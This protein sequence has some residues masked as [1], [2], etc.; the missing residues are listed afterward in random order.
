MVRGRTR[1]AVQPGA[2]G[3]SRDAL[4]AALPAPLQG[5]FRTGDGR[6]RTDGHWW[7]VWPLDRLV[8]DNLDARRQ[9]TLATGFL[10]FGDDGTGDGFCLPADGADEVVRWSWIDQEVVETIGNV[11]HF[12]AEWV[13]DQ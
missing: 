5:V 13:P 2:T 6:F 10:V 11:A 12:L 8:A 4:G 1:S 9:G 7:V 3:T